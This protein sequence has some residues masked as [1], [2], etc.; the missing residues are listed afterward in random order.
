MRKLGI[1]K[2]TIQVILN[3]KGGALSL[4]ALVAGK[5]R[6]IVVTLVLYHILP[7]K[8]NRGSI[9]NENLNA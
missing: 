6:R 5:T 4:A 3:C 9:K 1:G 7:F 8:T 2:S